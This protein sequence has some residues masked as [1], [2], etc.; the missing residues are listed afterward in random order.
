MSFDIEI[1]TVEFVKLA[2]GHHEFDYEIDK[3]FFEYY[4]NHDIVDAHLKVEMDIHKTGNMMIADIFTQGIFKLPC[5][6]CLTELSLPV[7]A[8]FK[9]IYHLNADHITEI[10]VIN[11]L[12]SDVVYLTPQEFKINIAQAI[13][14]SSLMDIPMIK[15]CDDFSENSCDQFMLDKLN[16]TSSES[17]HV[18][19]DPRWEKLKNIFNNEE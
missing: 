5:D 14:E 2:D 16:G 17:T 6:R 4:E 13:Y 11:D 8:E 1:F 7:E 15:T 12:D 19:V 9:L 18:Q 10:E 3:T